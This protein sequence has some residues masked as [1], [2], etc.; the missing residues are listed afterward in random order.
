MKEEEVVE[1]YRVLEGGGRALYFWFPRGEADLQ[2]I[3]ILAAYN[4]QE[5]KREHE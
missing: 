4:Q 2:Q 1:L 3:Y 5:K